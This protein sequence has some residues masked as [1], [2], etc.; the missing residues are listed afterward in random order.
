MAKK[1]KPVPNEPLQWTIHND[2][3]SVTVG[4]NTRI[5]LCRQR[6]EIPIRILLGREH[7]YL[8][9]REKGWNAIP[10][11]PHFCGPK[12]RPIPLVLNA[13]G[14]YGVAVETIPRP[15]RAMKRRSPS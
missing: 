1:K 14:I 3:Q 9:M 2:R 13:P 7:S 11:G 4:V 15:T 5:W 6:N 12:N 8:F 10:R